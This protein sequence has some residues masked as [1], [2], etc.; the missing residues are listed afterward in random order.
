MLPGKPCLALKAEIIDAP[1]RWMHEQ[2]PC[3]MTGF[4][5]LGYRFCNRAMLL[6]ATME[7]ESTSIVKHVLE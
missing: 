6:Q 7:F 4:C 1:G 3:K 5:K 2:L